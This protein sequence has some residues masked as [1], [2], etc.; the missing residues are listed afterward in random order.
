MS[1]TM[2]MVV[3][4]EPLDF[5]L[6]T[7]LQQ[8][9]VQSM[10]A[11]VARVAPVNHNLHSVQALL[12]AEMGRL[13][14][15][16]KFPFTTAVTEWRSC[17]QDAAMAC[18]SGTVV[19]G[20]ELGAPRSPQPDAVTIRD[21]LPFL[22]YRIDADTER[23]LGVCTARQVVR[24]SVTEITAAFADAARSI[25]VELTKPDAR[26]AERDELTEEL[27]RTLSRERSASVT[28]GGP[29]SDL[30][31]RRILRLRSAIRAIPLNKGT[32]EEILSIIQNT[33]TVVLPHASRADNALK[34]CD[35]NEQ[36]IGLLLSLTLGCHETLTQVK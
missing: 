29:D 9:I 24:E 26:S 28:S 25:L 16:H 17:L 27:N 14:G 11:P 19:L 34:G 33:E 5:E 1:R 4:G 6:M 22:V 30:F 15:Q 10:A 12:T 8:K 21:A 36:A 32:V 31:E 20:V 23:G 7:A 2:T 13:I 3:D 35:I 18:A